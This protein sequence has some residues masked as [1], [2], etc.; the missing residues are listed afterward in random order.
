MLPDRLHGPVGGPHR[1]GPL[2]GV[3]GGLLRHPRRP[4]GVFGHLLNRLGH[5]VDG[6]DGLPHLHRLH[7]AG[8]RQ[9]FRGSAHVLGGG[10]DLKGHVLHVLDHLAQLLGHLVEGIGDGPGEV[11]GHLGPG[12]QIALGQPADLVQ[13]AHDRLLDG[14]PLGAALHQIEQPVE[15]LVEAAAHLPQLVQIGLPIRR[16]RGPGLVVPLPD[17][18]EGAH[19]P[20]DGP[21]HR[22][23]GHEPDHQNHRQKGHGG[24]A[25]DLEEKA[26]D[27]GED[28]RPGHVHHHRSAAGDRRVGG[29]DRAA[30]P[31][32]GGADHRP[33]VSADQVGAEISGLSGQFGQAFSRQ[34][35]GLGGG[36][37]NPVPLVE[38][39]NPGGGVGL[40]ATQPFPQRSVRRAKGDGVRLQSA[41]GHELADRVG[42]G[43][44]DLLVARHD[45]APVG[46]DHDGQGEGHGQ[47]HGEHD[48]EL[49][50]GPDAEAEKPSLQSFQ[51]R[52]SFFSR[53]RTRFPVR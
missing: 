35:G 16:H 32:P 24:D 12:G 53:I 49:Q 37:G 23:V 30:V 21:D 26:V 46:G 10:D 33:P 41:G 48:A 27:R 28:F 18:V 39:E 2:L 13:Q 4:A 50:L 40:E 51:T 20:Q 17:L 1:L 31:G 47:Q 7:L 5:L 25:G 45:G 34:P 15:H 36:G 43:L 38:H 29:E 14:I 9:V 42:P 22:P 44:E 8:F 19:D 52:F 3:G 11:F 6:L